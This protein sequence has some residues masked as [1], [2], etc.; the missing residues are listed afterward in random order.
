MSRIKLNVT[1][2]SDYTYTKVITSWIINEMH[3]YKMIDD[4]DN[5][6]IWKTANQLYRHVECDKDDERCYCR[7]VDKDGNVTYERLEY[8][9]KGD[10]ITIAAS[11]KEE[12]E[13]KGEKQTVLQRVK[14]VDIIEK[15]PSYEEQ[16]QQKRAEQLASIQED[17]F[18]YT[19]PYKQ[20]K[21]HYSDCETVA[22]SFD[23]EDRTID[24]IIRAGRLKPNGTRFRHYKRFTL[25]NEAEQQIT[26]YA[27]S[28][29]TAM[30]RANKEYKN[31][32]WRIVKI[33]M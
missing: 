25:M 24:V 17:D 32:E 10:K 14:L 9:N 30:R 13:Y 29:E 21:E 4:E 1:L 31:H 23:D 12:S 3:I 33:H 7:N 5:V 27:I 18:V 6:Y 20:Y 28:E 11:V 19:M 15:T 2:A 26:Y 16:Q 22:C 8:I